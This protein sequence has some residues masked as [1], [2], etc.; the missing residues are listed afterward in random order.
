V[1][2]PTNPRRV[3]PAASL[4]T[5]SAGGFAHSAAPAARGASFETLSPPQLFWSKFFSMLTPAV[6]LAIV[7]YMVLPRFVPDLKGVGGAAAAALVG[8]AAAFMLVLAAAAYN[9]RSVC[10]DV[11]VHMTEGFVFSFRAMGSVPAIAGF[12]FIGVAGTLGPIAGMPAG[13]HPPGLLADLVRAGQAYMPH[14]PFFSAFGILFSG[15]ITGIDGSGFAGL[16]L[17]GALAGALGRSAGYNVA[18]LA[19]IG[20]M[21]SVWTGK[22]LCA[23]SALAAVAG[24]ARVPVLSVVRYLLLPIVCGLVMSTIFAVVYW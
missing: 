2:A 23:W 16:P 24:F 8:G 7:V 19:A 4:S 10:R 1:A 18:T 14:N 12:F 5:S 3:T 22:T 20:Q 17:T 15:M 6:F 13:S 11:A 9:I 21:G